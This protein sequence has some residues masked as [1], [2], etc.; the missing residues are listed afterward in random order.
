MAP[1]SSF[2]GLEGSVST[3]PAARRLGVS[4]AYV[5][6][7]VRDGRLRSIRT[8]LGRLIPRDALEEFAHQRERAT[9]S[10]GRGR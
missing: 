3:G 9:A 2:N 5:R 8:P 4:D 1:P 6:R 7:L 10:T